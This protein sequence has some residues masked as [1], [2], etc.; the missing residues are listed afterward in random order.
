METHVMKT[1]NLVIAAL[2]LSLGP[3]SE[4]GPVVVTALMA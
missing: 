3:I 4:P 2:T 1:L